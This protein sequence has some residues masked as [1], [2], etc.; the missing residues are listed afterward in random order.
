[1]AK[2]QFGHVAALLQRFDPKDLAE[3]LNLKPEAIWRW[4]TK[5]R[6]PKRALLPDIAE[7]TGIALDKLKEARQADRLANRNIA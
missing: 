1:M 6:L 7:A 2:S 4:Q 5:R 3:K